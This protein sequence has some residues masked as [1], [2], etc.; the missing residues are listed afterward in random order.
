MNKKVIVLLLHNSPKAQLLIMLHGNNMQN[1][2]S[3]HFSTVETLVQ[4]YQR[5]AWYRGYHIRLHH[6]TTFSNEF[7]FLIL[8]NPY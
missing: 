1:V 4:P 6:H 3:I 5:G 7:Q 2:F 8:S